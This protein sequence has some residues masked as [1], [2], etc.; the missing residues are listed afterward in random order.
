MADVRGHGCSCSTCTTRVSTP[1]IQT[2]KWGS[3][4]GGAAVSVSL[5]SYN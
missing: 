4:G 1:E 3:G 5:T 2:D